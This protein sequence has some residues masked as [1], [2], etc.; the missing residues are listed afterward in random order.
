[1]STITCLTCEYVFHMQIIKLSDAVQPLPRS[2]T[3]FVHGV[4]RAFLAAGD[5]A[6]EPPQPGAA[7][8]HFTHGSYFIGKGVWGKVLACQPFLSLLRLRAHG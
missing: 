7:G 3:L 2:A 6:A 1:M 5:A 8:R 4:S